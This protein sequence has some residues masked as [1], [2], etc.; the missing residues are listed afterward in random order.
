MPTPSS[1]CTV[2]LCFGRRSFGTPV[3]PRP[4][5]WARSHLNPTGRD[6]DT[7]ERSDKRNTTRPP[8]SP[9][10]RPSSLVIPVYSYLPPSSLVVYSTND[11]PL[12][13]P[14]LRFRNRGALDRLDDPEPGSRPSRL[15]EGEGSPS[16]SKSPRSRPIVYYWRLSFTSVPL[17]LVRRSLALPP[18]PPPPPQSRSVIAWISL[19]RLRD[20][21]SMTPVVAFTFP[22][23][24]APT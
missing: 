15:P 12:N 6:C 19:D 18:P 2:P 16:T 14:N 24:L 7:G 11:P 10:A 23:L 17:P 1:S 8:T 9:G 4:L 22:S 3:C 13:H 21:C 5:R 20:S